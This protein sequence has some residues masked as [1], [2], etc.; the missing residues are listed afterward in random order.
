VHI[1]F[2][3]GQDRAYISPSFVANKVALRAF[4]NKVPTIT[5]SNQ[6]QVNY[7]PR[8]SVKKKKTIPLESV[9]I[10]SLAGDIDV[11]SSCLIPSVIPMVNL[12][13]IGFFYRCT[14]ARTRTG[15]SSKMFR[16][17]SYVVVYT[18]L[19]INYHKSCMHPINVDNDALVIMSRCFGCQIGD[20]LGSGAES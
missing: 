2:R 8:V 18:S 20:L 6:L 19:H 17:I 1:H 5:I 7:S 4:L 3:P 13:M 14:P 15:C 10:S 9:F 16:R 12:G 11:E